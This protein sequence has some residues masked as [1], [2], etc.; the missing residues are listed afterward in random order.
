MRLE[1][2]LLNVKSA[3]EFHSVLAH[4]LDFGPYYGKNLSALWDV[5]TTD[6]ERPLTIV[7]RNADHCRAT[8][9]EEYEK[10]MSVFRKV[11]ERD[12][13]KPAES[14]LTIDVHED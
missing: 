11:A 13:G 5:M 2:N 10:I 7:F 1:I 14:R 8:L 12:A 4:Q 9:G 6:V 3:G